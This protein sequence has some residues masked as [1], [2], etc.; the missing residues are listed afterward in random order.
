MSNPTSVT[1]QLKHVHPTLRDAILAGESRSGE[2][3]RLLNELV[4]LRLDRA[5]TD[6]LAEE[7]AEG[8]QVRALEENLGSAQV[9]IEGLREA[10][11]QRK[12][13]IAQ[14][15]QQVRGLKESL[16]LA[17]KKCA[18]NRADT[19]AALDHAVELIVYFKGKAEDY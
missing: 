11:E 19:R 10:A 8:D 3:V 13:E 14:L 16:A 4:Q 1:I 5:S 18:G 7:T 15:Q 17:D 2:T 6:A 12:K 9:T